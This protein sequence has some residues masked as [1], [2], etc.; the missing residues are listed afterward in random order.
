MKALIIVDMQNDFMPNGA[1][2]V[3]KGDEIVPLI[4][5]LIPKFPLVVATKDWHPPNHVS[6]AINHPGK[7]IGDVIKV[8][9]QDQIL[10]PTH[11]VR[12]TFGAELISSLDKTKII[13]T[14]FKG[15][16]TNIDSYSAFFDN[17]HLKTTGLSDFLKSRE[18]DKVYFAGLTTEYCVLYSTIDAIELG[19]SV[20]VIADACRPINL[21]PH[22]EERA[23]K[24]MKDKGAKI[25]QSS[26][27]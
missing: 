7:V 6:F 24:T 14:F 15:T 8:R 13:S 20:Y 2:G 21:D 25:I 1:L 16:D 11:C 23:L 9:D 27:L 5:S 12:N 4:N 19:F 22:D 3:P 10:W 18:V 17:A 26:D